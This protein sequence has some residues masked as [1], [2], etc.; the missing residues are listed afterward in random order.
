VIAIFCAVGGVQPQTETVWRQ[1]DK[2]RVP[3]IAF[4]NKMDRL[5]ADFY[6]VVDRIRDRLGANAVPVQLPIGVENT[7]EGIIDLVKM[8]A[9]TYLDDLG[10]ESEVTDIPGD[11]VNRALEY[12][13][14]MIESLADVDEQFMEK[15]LEGQKITADEMKSAIRKGAISGQLVPVLC[16][17]AFRNKGVQLL[18]DA[19]IDYLPSPLDVDAVAGINPR[20]GAVETRDP[21][22]QEPFCALAFKI[23]ADPYVG[24]LTFLRAYSGRLTK[25]AAVFNANK[26][27]RERIGRV[28]RMHAN[29]REDISYIHTGDIVAAVGLQET[30]TGDTLSDVNKPILLE[31]IQFP[32]PVIS[33]AIEPKTKAD[34]DKMGLALAR[35]SSEDPTFKIHT[36][37]ETGQTIISGMGELHL[38]IIIDR[39]FREF[40]VQ[41]NHGRP[42]VA[43]K[44]T[45]AR[46]ARGEGRYV[47]QTG[48]R[49]QYGHCELEVEPLRSGEGFEIVSKIAGG[50]IPKEFIHAVEAGI[51]EAAEAGVLA[52]YPVVDVRATIADGSYHEVD[53]SEV[54]FKIAGSMA[55]KAAMRKGGPVLKE[56]IMAVEIVTPENYMG[57]V[58]SDV[59]ARRGHIHGIEPGYGG[60]Q[61]IKADVPLAEMFGYA[62]SLRSLTQ[63]R[64]SYTMEPARYEV[65]PGTLADELV[66][67]SQ[68]QQLA[69]R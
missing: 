66:A 15:Y 56:P 34:Q 61:V 43:Y 6:R 26:G 29:H 63:G 12:R 22:D 50:A 60:T 11:L 52:G 17:A 27:M 42:Q 67:R 38:E 13:E 31:T 9:V 2:Y 57:D 39:L 24:K 5:G 47:R 8:Q 59:N 28:L 36:D 54:A 33:V 68:G 4:I 19:V 44:E 65:V 23:M 1:A 20:N 62:T 69:V 49:G 25:G 55:M 51:R 40:N 18:I 46:H 41:A 53:S 64:A 58:I 7:F 30:V 3:R 35:L 21:S 10:A 45:I 32:L 14:A 48:G 37:E 16:G